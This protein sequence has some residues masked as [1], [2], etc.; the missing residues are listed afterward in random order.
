MATNLNVTAYI[1]RETGETQEPDKLPT[2]ALE[3]INSTFFEPGKSL[4]ITDIVNVGGST[5]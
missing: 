3:K 1:Q 2:N 5:Q 4:S